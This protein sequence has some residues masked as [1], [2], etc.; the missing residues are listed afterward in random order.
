MAKTSR[1]PESTND[2]SAAG[3]EKSAEQ[4]VQNGH[5]DTFAE[6]WAALSGQ[7]HDICN[8]GDGEPAIIIIADTKES[9]PKILAHGHPYELAVLLTQVLNKVRSTVLAPLKV[10]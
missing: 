3:A 6:R 1:P 9:N 4:A 7:F 10:E 8:A 2:L 5:P